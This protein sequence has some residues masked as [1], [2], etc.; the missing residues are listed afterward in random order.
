MINKDTKLF[1]SFSN[2]PGNNGCTFFNNKFYEDGIDAI[3]KS[4]YSDD[5]KETIRAVKH[6]KFSGF[7]VSSPFKTSILDYVDDVDESASKIGASNTI[8][9]KNSR[10]V[11]YNT[12]YIGVSKFFENKNISHIN[13]IGMGGFGKAAFYS[14]INLGMSIS[15]VGRN[16]IDKIDDVQNQFFFNATPIEIKS[17]NNIIIDARPFTEVGKEIFKYQAEAQY[18]LYIESIK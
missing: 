3:Y 11:A 9:I 13:L 6:L 7:A 2:N 14:F 17:D 4:F 1:G 5:I 15:F 18:K 8:I 10:L 16:N 12:D